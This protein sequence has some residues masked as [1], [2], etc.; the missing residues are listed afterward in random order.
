M[1]KYNYNFFQIPST[2]IEATGQG[3]GNQI[4]RVSSERISNFGALQFGVKNANDYTK[5]AFGENAFVQNPTIPSFL[6]TGN[7]GNWGGAINNPYVV[8]S[9]INKV[10]HDE[11]NVMTLGSRNTQGVNQPKFDTMDTS[12][13]WDTANGH[14]SYNTTISGNGGATT[15]SGSYVNFP[16]EGWAT[17]GGRT[18]GPY[19]YQLV[20]I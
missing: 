6:P 7:A 10:R 2:G 20:N 1:G 11:F 3:L 19:G 16:S 12:L 5:T 4:S 18:G 9:T 8:G 14:I 13:V 17:F 15:V